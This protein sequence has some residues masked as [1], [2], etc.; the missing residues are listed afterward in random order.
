MAW[1]IENPLVVTLDNQLIYQTVI[2][3][4][5][6]MKLYDQVL[7]GALDRV[8]ARLKNI[9]FAAKAG[10][11]KI[12]VAF[13]RKTFAESD[14]QMQMF[15]PGG[16]QDRLYR[17]NSFQLL[18]PFGASGLGSTPSR[19]RIFICHPSD[20]QSRSSAACAEEDHGV[21][22]QTRISPAGFR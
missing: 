3:G 4:E 16:G 20:E 12:G 9:R 6:D 1:S 18:G 15:S 11:H 22:G 5:E 7:N 10:P 8:N 13:K 2:G 14:D 21:S 17:V 19:D